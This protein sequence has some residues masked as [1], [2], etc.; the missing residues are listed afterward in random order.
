MINFAN[1]LAGD[2][3][4]AAGYAAPNNILIENNFLDEAMDHSG[5]P[6]YYALNIRECTNCTIRYNSWLQEPR[7]PNG[8]VSLNNRFIGNLGPMSPWNCYDNGVSYSHNVWKG[9]RCGRTDVKVRTSASR[10]PTPG[11]FN[12]HLRRNS[13][14]INHGGRPG[15]R[16]ATSTASAGREALER[17]PEP[18]SGAES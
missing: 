8:E 11:R 16:G 4:S 6:T 15:T 5:G 2:S 13:P 3:K 10:I 12:L 18:T 17:T 7:M 9:A 14:A 1:D